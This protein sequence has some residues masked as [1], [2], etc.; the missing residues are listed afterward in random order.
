MHFKRYEKLVQ[1]EDYLD[2]IDEKYRE[3]HFHRIS[4]GICDDPI[5]S[6]LYVD[7]LASLERL[8][9]HCKSRLFLFAK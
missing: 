4:D 9:D 5:A 6:S 3:R 2:L 7:I 1:D 8:G